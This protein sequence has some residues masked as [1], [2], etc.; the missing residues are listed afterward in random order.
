MGNAPGSGREPASPPIGF[1]VYGLDRSWPGVR[2]LEVFG[3]QIG[4]PPRSVSLAHQT[5]DGSSLIMV[6]THSR[7]ATGAP[8]SYRVPTH[9]QAAK[10]GKSPLEWVAFA[11][12][13][14]LINLTL[15]VLSLPRPP[16]FYQVLVD[17][18]EQARSEYVRWPTVRWQVDGVPVTARVWRFA[19][20]WAAF[21]DAVAGVYLH[22]SGVGT[23]PD[24]LPLAVLRDGRAYHFDLHQPLD[25][26]VMS[27]SRA[28]AGADN[29]PDARRPD[30][31]ADH[32]RLMRDPGNR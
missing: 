32:L 21:T 17:Q 5:R 25:P 14:E 2:W 10:L 13:F 20:G 11:A 18:A 26:G 19:A 9:A 7:L 8:R 1:P 31:H 30:W 16:G 15:P 28:A 6:T 23:G 3:D 4:D 24:D 27:A 12:A 22:A 29:L